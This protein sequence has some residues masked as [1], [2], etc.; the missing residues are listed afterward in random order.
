MGHKR[1]WG[2]VANSVVLSR[3]VSPGSAQGGVCMKWGAIA[4][5]ARC[6]G[7]CHVV[8]GQNFLLGA[9]LLSLLLLPMPGAMARGAAN[10]PFSFAHARLGHSSA[11]TRIAL[12]S[13]GGLRSGHNLRGTTHHGSSGASASARS[14]VFV[15]K[16]VSVS[17]GDS[18]T[19]EH[20]GQLEKVELWGI[21]CPRPGQPYSLQARQYTTTKALNQTVRVRIKGHSRSGR[22]LGCVDMTSGNTLNADLIGSGLAWWSRKEAKDEILLAILEDTARQDKRGLWAGKD[23]VP[24]SKWRKRKGGRMKAEG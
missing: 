8:S 5:M 13:G 19:V 23:P 20:D 18:I 2:R 24:P 9:G 11:A 16:C 17:A 3:E 1:F 15:G 10:A 6:A 12:R 7:G 21:D 14:A 4:G 22:I